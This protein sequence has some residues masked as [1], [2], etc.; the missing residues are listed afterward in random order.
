MCQRPPKNCGLQETKAYFFYIKA[1]ADMLA[2][3]CDVISNPGF[4]HLSCCYAWGGCHLRVHGPRWHTIISAFQPM[5]GKKT[6]KGRSAPCLKQHNPGTYIYCFCSHPT[7]HCHGHILGH[8]R[9]G[10][11]VLILGSCVPNHERK[12]NR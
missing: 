3:I 10:Y 2:L 6:D 12:E 4:F 7:D 9:L 5:G 1:L 8:R 11:I